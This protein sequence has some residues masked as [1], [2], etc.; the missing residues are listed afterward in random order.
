MLWEDRRLIV[1]LDGPR[2]HSTPAQ[3]ASDAKRQEWLESR[4]YTVIRF[5]HDDVR[6]RPDWVATR[7]RAAL[8]ALA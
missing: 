6:H 5:T 4:G 7:V 1:E 8:A 2:A 3:L